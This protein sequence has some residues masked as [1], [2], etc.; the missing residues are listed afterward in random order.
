MIGIIDFLGNVV[1]GLI[2]ILPMWYN[3][4]FL[5]IRGISPCVTDFVPEEISAVVCRVIGIIDFLGNV[6]GG[7]ICILPMWYNVNRLA[8]TRIIPARI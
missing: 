3:V 2:C 4:N 7:L 8:I 6:V 5:A 1:S